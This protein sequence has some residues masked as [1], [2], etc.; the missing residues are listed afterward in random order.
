MDNERIV[1]LTER[2]KAILFAVIEQFAEVPQPVGSVILAKLFNVSSATVRAEM[3]QLELLGLL[4]QEHS[5]AGRTPTDKGYRIYVNA[6]TDGEL[7]KNHSDRS[8]RAIDAR[9][10]ANLERIDLAIRGAVDSLAEATGNLG[11]ATIGSQL[12]LSGLNKLFNQPD[13][14]EIDDARSVAR[15]LDNLEPWLREAQPNEP[16]S[17]Y[18]GTENPIGAEA[19][20]SLII[21]RFRSP[22]SDRSYIGM[23]GATRQNYARSMWLVASVGKILEQKLN[24]EIKLLN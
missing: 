2:Q 5:S 23:L 13:F 22:L 3:A 15:L 4:K 17:V 6:I 14:E 21:S 19:G 8:I 7:Q 12:Y 11:L 10:E 20:A 9:I 1:A 18:I 24:G 16:L